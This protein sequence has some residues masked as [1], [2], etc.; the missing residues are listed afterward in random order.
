MK[1]SIDIFG[2]GVGAESFLLETTATKLTITTI[3]T[4]E[5]K[6]HP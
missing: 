1:C 6:I 4:I 2:V 3:D 5:I